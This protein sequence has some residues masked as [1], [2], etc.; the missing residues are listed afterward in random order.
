[1]Y[2]LKNFKGLPHRVEYVDEI[3]GIEFVNDSKATN[4]D[5]VRRCLYSIP[6]PIILIMGGRDKGADFSPLRERIKDKVREIILLGEARK[7][8]KTQLSSISS[9]LEV[10]GLKEAVRMAFRD[11]KKGDCILLSP[12]CASFDQFRDYRERGE[13]F[14]KEVKKI[15]EEIE[16]KS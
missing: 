7:K 13:V 2:T 5:A 1:R 6:R 8:I 12:G 11:A 15:K 3:E 14:K 4:V 10:E 9:I 16:K